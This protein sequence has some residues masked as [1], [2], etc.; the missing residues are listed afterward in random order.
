MELSEQGDGSFSNIIAPCTQDQL[1]DMVLELGKIQRHPF[2]QVSWAS[3]QA[4]FAPN[5]LI[6]LFLEPFTL[7]AQAVAHLAKVGPL[8]ACGTCIDNRKCEVIP[9]Q[10]FCPPPPV[11]Q[12]F[13]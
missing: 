7:L 4:L 6:V 1:M 5:D 10:L 12:V 3:L 11:R 2:M 13:A 8:A 9:L